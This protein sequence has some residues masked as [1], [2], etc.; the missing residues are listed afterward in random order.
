MAVSPGLGWSNSLPDSEAKV[1]FVLNGTAL[2]FTGAG[3]H[4]QVRNGLVH[5]FLKCSI[6]VKD[7]GLTNPTKGRT[8]SKQLLLHSFA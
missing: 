1:D 2:S 5:P 7:G 4:D 6:A 8:F 3:Y